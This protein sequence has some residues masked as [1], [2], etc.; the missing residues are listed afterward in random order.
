[1]NLTSGMTLEQ[2]ESAKAHAIEATRRAMASGASKTEADNAYDL[3]MNEAR[4]MMQL[5]QVK[6]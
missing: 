6:I 3:A 4:V 1:M 2:M 5:P